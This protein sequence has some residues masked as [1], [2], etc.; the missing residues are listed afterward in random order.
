[1]TAAE[2]ILALVTAQRGAELVLSRRHTNALMARGAIEVAASHYPLMV[3]VH[4]SWLIALW[5]FGHDPPV[6]PAALAAY[7]ALQGLRIWVMATLG[8]RWT[9]RIIVLPDAPLVARGPYRYIRHPNYAVVVGE[10]ATLP[11]MLGLPWIAAVFTA[12]NAAVLF[13]RIRAE[14][15]ALQL[16]RSM[17]AEG[18]PPWAKQKTSS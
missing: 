1:V 9:T 3:A 14:N 6:N 15:H 5:V 18:P 10:I 12:L 2:I 16:S 8:G 13:I 4:T 7:L 11:L 17:A